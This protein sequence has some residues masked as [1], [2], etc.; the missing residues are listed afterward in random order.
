MGSEDYEHETGMYVES[1]TDAA[2]AAC[3]LLE[4]HVQRCESCPPEIIEEDADYHFNRRCEDIETLQMY[5]AK[6]GK[7]TDRLCQVALTSSRKR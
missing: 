2:Q 4:D 1:W 7:L 5:I 6:L 3:D